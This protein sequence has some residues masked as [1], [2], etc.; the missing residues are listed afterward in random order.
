[1]PD[2]VALE[3]MVAR[4]LAGTVGLAGAGERIEVGLD[5]AAEAKNIAL[6]IT[7]S[8]RSP[9]DTADCHFHNLHRALEAA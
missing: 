7:R 9:V 8:P 3:R 1:M 2:G 4:L 6:R 5:T